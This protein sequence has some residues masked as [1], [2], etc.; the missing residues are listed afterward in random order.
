MLLD[1]IIL[2]F[3]VATVVWTIR[4]IRAGRLP[5]RGARPSS[6]CDRCGQ[7]NVVVA[8]FCARCGV[9]LTDSRVSPNEGAMKDER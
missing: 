1:V 6:V 3:I 4:M 2:V 7:G 8:K 9:A 5:G